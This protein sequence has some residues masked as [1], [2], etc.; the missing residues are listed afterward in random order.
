M[1]D[2]SHLIYPLM[3]TYHPI[4]SKSIIEH[5][6]ECPALSPSEYFELHPVSAPGTDSASSAQFRARGR[7][8]T[9]CGC[10]Q[11]PDQVSKMQG[12]KSGDLLKIIENSSGHD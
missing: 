7:D 9:H 6:K 10:L 2:K 12:Q 8:P 1:Q 3:S 11:S 4:F 5:E